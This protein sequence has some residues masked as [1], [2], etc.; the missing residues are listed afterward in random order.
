MEVE[1]RHNY[2]NNLMIIKDDNIKINDYRIN[3]L[4]KNKINGLLEMYIACVDGRAELSYVISSKQSIK[5]VF[6]KEKIDVKEVKMMIECTLKIIENMKIYLLDPNSIILDLNYI[7][8]DMDK[9]EIM[10]CYYPNYCQDFNKSFYEL[11]QNMLT[12]VNH[13]DRKAVELIYGIFQVCNRPGFLIKNI[14]EYIESS[15]NVVCDRDM[16]EERKTDN[17][18]EEKND[19]KMDEDEEDMYVPKDNSENLVS[20]ILKF[21][22]S[23]GKNRYKDVPKDYEYKYNENIIWNEKKNEIKIEKSI[24]EDIGEKESEEGETMLVSDIMLSNNRKL[25]SMSEKQDLIINEYPYIIGKVSGKTDGV[26]KDNSVSRIHAKISMEENKYFIED[27]NSKNGTYVNDRLL[28]PYEK[29]AILIG[30]KI[31]IAFYDFIFR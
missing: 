2:D 4:M 20:K 17:C 9:N 7:F 29:I 5:E 11:L 25:L 10:F 6:S 1:Y 15:Q 28:D 22:R 30:D 18:S 24:E 12:Y 31:T 13:E 19:Y 8:L 27:L 16:Y 3:M 26:I 23:I 14:H 21:I